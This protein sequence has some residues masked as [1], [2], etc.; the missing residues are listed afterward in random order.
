MPD[1]TPT[2]AQI[3]LVF[4][5]VRTAISSL[6]VLA[7][8]AS[9]AHATPYETFV[10]V[11][12]EGDLLDLL[13]AGTITEDT[14]NELLDL[15]TRGVDISRADRN[16]LYTLPNLTYEDVDAILAYRKLNKGRIKD[17]AELVT[18]GALSEDKLLAIASF[19]ITREQADK[20]FAANGWIRVMTRANPHDFNPYSP[21]DP[22]LPP[23]GLRTRFTALRY[24]TAGAALTTTRLDIG[25]PV[26]DPARGAL[27]ADQRSYQFRAP[28]AYLKYENDHLAVIGGSYRI[29]FGQRLT[30]DNSSAY[31]PNGV[32]I[33]DQLFYSAD[34]NRACRESQGELIS[35]PCTGIRSA[36]YVTPD[37][38]WRDGLFGIAAGAK[39][40]ELP[41]GHMQLYGFGSVARKSIYQYELVD[42]NKCNDP[43]DDD[44]SGGVC[45]APDVFV[46]PEG[47][48]LDATSRHSF[49]TLP[50]VFQERL[51]GGNLTY[52]ADRRNSVGIT[53]YGAQH[54]NLVG[55]VDLDYQEW[56]RF[57]TGKKF[58]AV[59]ANFS[60]GRDWLDLFGEAT[61][62][63][64]AMP[65]QDP[66]LTPA[67][68]GGG[69][70]AILRMTATRKK[71]E[72][73]VV[74][75]YFSTDYL[76][77]YGRPIAQND[78]FEGQR[79]RDEAGGRVRYIRTSKE[80]QIR[81]LAD[82]WTNP[83]DPDK[84]VK[85]DTY[86]RVNVK[87]TPV[88]WLGLW[89]RFQDKNLKLTGHD[90]CFEISN[91]LDET[92]ETIPCAGMQ[93][94]TIVR[95][96][97]EPNNRM[98]A[99]LQVE[100]QLLD[101]N[102]QMELVNKFRQDLAI[103]AVGYYRPGPQ[104]RARVRVRFLDEAIHDNTYQ[105][106]SIAGLVDVTQRV[107]ERDSVRV[108]IDTKF[109]LDKRDSTLDRVPNPE[110]SLWL[111][112]EAKL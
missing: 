95:A 43:H 110:L 71:E 10:D 19:I 13:A 93:L 24:V 72:L 34:L 17:P 78:Q 105:E 82:V 30:F 3:V 14:Y 64:D 90:Q 60:F 96:Q 22:L 21:Q 98:S 4:G 32:Y 53:G 102:T 31:S 81:A 76:N 11:D 73:E 42:R 67:K 106:R 6:L 48:L 27:V 65:E 37:F 46:K 33:D 28:K 108:R 44:A 104:T 1:L 69:P 80:M 5:W 29:G 68:G 70:A 2:S 87:T 35:S 79:A 23:L 107:R 8:A 88:L 99:T 54:I 58:G 15:L 97:Y 57:P 49:A 91:E 36:E 103:W 85:I 50:N 59:G 7:C 20:P 38:A 86:A 83:S 61:V 63:I 55:G 51:A 12:N 75:R 40:I 100:H 84:P 25:N 62:S 109:W 26:Y 16:E 89:E 9:I 52:F 92:G 66:S 56:S 45:A 47:S 41:T 39:K 112:Y 77:P 18:S 74:A 111:F 101:D 94:S